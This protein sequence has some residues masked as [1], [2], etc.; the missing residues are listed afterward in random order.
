MLHKLK[1]LKLLAD[2]NIQF[3][4]TDYLRKLNFDIVDVKELSFKG[5]TDLFLFEYAKKN[6]RVILTHDSDFGKIIFAGELNFIGIIYLR[7]GHFNP[8][9]TI[10]SLKAFF[11]TK[12]KISIPFIV[13]LEKYSEKVKIRIREF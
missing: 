2:E 6:Q 9:N 12:R 7:P 4:V 8:D 11:N 5:K 10:Y 13:S 3:E 1:E